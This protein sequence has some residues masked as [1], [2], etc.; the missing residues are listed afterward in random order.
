M[1]KLS[2]GRRLFYKLT[3][4]LLGAIAFLRLLSTLIMIL[5]LFFNFL[6][7]PLHFQNEDVV[8]KLTISIK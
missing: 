2:E 5:L 4:F 7:L 8:V 1:Y 6:I 3:A